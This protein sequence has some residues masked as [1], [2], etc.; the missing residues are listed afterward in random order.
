MSGE[1]RDNEMLGDDIQSMAD[2]IPLPPGEGAIA[3]D[4]QTPEHKEEAA[5]EKHKTI[6]NEQ[7]IDQSNGRT[8]GEEGPA[9]TQNSKSDSNGES[10]EQSIDCVKRGQDEEA[11]QKS[12]GDSNNE[13]RTPSQSGDGDKIDLA[14]A[15]EHIQKLI[16]QISATNERLGKLESKI[17]QLKKNK[18]G[19]DGEDSEESGSDDETSSHKTQSAEKASEEDSNEGYPAPKTKFRKTTAREDRSEFLSPFFDSD[20]R[21]C[22]WVLYTSTAE[23]PSPPGT[24]PMPSTIEVTEIGIRS[25]AIFSFLSEEWD[26]TLEKDGIIHMRWPFRT[27]LRKTEQIHQHAK[28]LE[29]LYG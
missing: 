15:P 21:V 25:D 11:I 16:D 27:L 24:Y 14:K 28:W 1:G 19:D 9:A 6:S 23:T 8:G 7:P 26:Y 17:L 20:P 4:D 22:L 3:S 2:Q 12:D 13:A 10:A 18:S 29:N 5:T